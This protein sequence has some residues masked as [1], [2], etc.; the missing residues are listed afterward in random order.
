MPSGEGGSALPLAE[1]LLE[2][3]VCQV[4]EVERGWAT[5]RATWQDEKAVAMPEIRR[6]LQIL[7]LEQLEFIFGQKTCL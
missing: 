7:S 2:K 4:T 3:E 5:G 1:G 6:A